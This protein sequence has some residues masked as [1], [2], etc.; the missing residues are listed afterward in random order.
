MSKNPWY[1]IGIKKYTKNIDISRAKD[2]KVIKKFM[3]IR[4]LIMVL[5]VLVAAFI[6]A[7]VWS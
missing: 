3:I 4:N 1:D 7:L 2:P 5:N 6:L